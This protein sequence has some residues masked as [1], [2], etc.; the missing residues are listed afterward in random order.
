MT[1]MNL[2]NGSER[3]SDYFPWDIFKSDVTSFLLKNIKA[4]Q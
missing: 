2:K 1:K 4:F 3:K